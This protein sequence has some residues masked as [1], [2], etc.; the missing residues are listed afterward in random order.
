MLAAVP[1]AGVNAAEGP[2]AP[3]ISNIAFPG[4]DAATL[5]VHLDLAGIACSSGSACASGSAKPS[6]VLLTMGLPDAVA[7]GSLRFSF[8]PESTDTDIARVLAVLPKIV[9]RAREST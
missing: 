2:R 1:D 5:L 7:R 6:H 3:H 4:A 9:A 8:S